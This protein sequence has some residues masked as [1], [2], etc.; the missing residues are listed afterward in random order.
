MKNKL[1]I[2]AT[3]IFLA[4]CSSSS[5]APKEDTLHV[6]GKASVSAIPEEVMIHVP[7]RVREKSFQTCSDQL[8][9][10][11][12]QLSKGFEK[13]GFEEDG[14]KTD[15]YSI[16]ENYEYLNNKRVKT[17]YLG[18]I[19]IQVQKQYSVELVSEVI[20]LLKNLRL[21]YSID[22]TLSEA[23]KLDLT[24]ASIKNA[25]ADAQLKA[26]T[27]ADELKVKLV[28]VSNIV[29][30]ASQVQHPILMRNESFDAPAMKGN[31]IEFNPSEIKINKV[32]NIEW[33]IKN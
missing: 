32:V 14:I 23:Q 21:T 26:T 15:N 10:K 7:I 28:R 13:I 11:I 18:A 17:G 12:D 16:T 20:E 6:V 30:D 5:I 19:T 31:L 9:S 3:I 22:F 4:S 29:Y 25:I 1:L 8:L 27:L 2:I 24:D 33:V